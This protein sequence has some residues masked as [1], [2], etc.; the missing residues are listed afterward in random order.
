MLAGEPPFTGP[1]AQAI[2]ARVITERP[3]PLDEVRDTAPPGAVAAVHTALAKLPADRQSSAEHF[4]AGL[5]GPSASPISAHHARTSGP[6]AGWRRWRV[7]GVAAAAVALGAATDRVA[8]RSPAPAAAAPVRFS[9]IPDSGFALGRFAIAPDGSAIAFWANRPD[10]SAELL[11][12][13]MDDVDARPLAVIPHGQASGV[14]QGVFFSADAKWVGYIANGAIEKLPTGGGT[15]VMLARAPNARGAA[16]WAPDGTIYY[17]ANGGALMQVPPDGRPPERLLALGDG[18]RLFAPSM[19]PDGR[20]MLVSVASVSTEQLLWTVLDLRTGKIGALHPGSMAAYVDPGDVVYAD[21]NGR[22]WRQPLDIEHRAPA[23]APRSVPRVLADAFAVSRTGSLVFLPTDLR[24]THLMLVDRQGH[25]RTLPG[26]AFAWAPRFSP[27]G[28]RV[29]FAAS[30][31]SG[32]AYDVWVLDLAAGTSQRITTDSVDNNDAQWSPDEN[33]LV[34]SSNHDSS[35]KDLYIDR[36]DGGGG[37]RLLLH[38]AGAQWSSDWSPDGRWILFT[39]VAP[40]GEND[41]WM[42]RA[43]GKEARPWLAT[44]FLERGGTFSPDGP[45]VAYISNE[46]G[47]PK[48]YIQSFPTPGGKRVVSTNAGN[49]PVWRGDGRELYYCSDGQL[50]AV[51][52]AWDADGPRVTGRTPLFKLPYVEGPHANYDATADG[53]RFVVNV[54]S[55]LANR[56]VVELNSMSPRSTP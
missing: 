8:H 7:A 14:G 43:D 16:T 24:G 53:Q 39:N 51:Q 9:V 36:A 37:T 13:G 34:Y 18:R 45:W 12:R 4:S 41:I 19:L 1:N 3:R 17:D 49:N 5:A 25:G 22:I 31:T 21:E 50:V 30:A 15:P 44:P 48:V 28:R 27:D 10:G 55:E 42:V 26:L 54:G 47:E 38:R 20:S 23:G 40:D 52:L 33:L 29:A 6:V 35:V 11:I 46:S 32:D 56:I 2:L